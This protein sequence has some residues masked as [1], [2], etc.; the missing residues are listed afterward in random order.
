MKEEVKKGE[1]RQEERRK[2][3]Y[4]NME[5]NMKEGGGSKEGRGLEGERKGKAKY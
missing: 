3:K 1:G 2:A 4:Q 5:D